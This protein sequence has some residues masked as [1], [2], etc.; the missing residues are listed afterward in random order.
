[1]WLFYAIE[2]CRRK[3]C[4]GNTEAWHLLAIVADD[5]YRIVTHLCLFGREAQTTDRQQKLHLLPSAEILKFF[6]INILYRFSKKTCGNNFVMVTT[7]WYFK[8]SK[9]I[10]ICIPITAIVEV[11]SLNIGYELWNDIQYTYRQWTTVYLQIFQRNISR[12]WCGYTSH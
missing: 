10:P 1:M 5:L 11:Y 3:E 8:L 4:V 2:S 9:A 7:D 12:A 6:S